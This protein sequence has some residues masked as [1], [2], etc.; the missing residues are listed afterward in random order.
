[1]LKRKLLLSF[2]FLFLII[3]IGF[4][5]VYA[6]D[7]YGNRI[8]NVEV[9][10]QTISVYDVNYED[11]E[12]GENI[13]ID[14]Y[15]WDMFTFKIITRLNTTALGYGGII[16]TYQGI[17]L[18]IFDDE[19]NLVLATGMIPDFPMLI[20]Y[21][22][23]LFEYKQYTSDP[24]ELNMFE[25]MFYINIT[26]WHNYEMT[27]DLEDW[28]L[29]EEW[30]INLKAEN[31]IPPEEEEPE[32]ENI[33]LFFLAFVGSMFLCPISFAGAVKMKEPKL[34]GIGILFLLVFISTLFIIV[35]FNPFYG[36]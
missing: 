9:L 2:F 28:V 10:Q 29:T 32:F 27:G 18:Q 8:E 14:S 22:P 12:E 19:D 5:S 11:Y 36:D 23:L 33:D 26:L 7:E 24:I 17:G 13:T 30:K 1:M 25:N 35:G 31:Y 20:N 34:I 21:P 4:I 16:Y 6:T 15:L 3:S